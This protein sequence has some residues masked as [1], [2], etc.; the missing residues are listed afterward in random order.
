MSIAALIEK[1]NT[2]AQWLPVLE[3]AGVFFLIMLYIWRLRYVRH[4]S[5]LIILG[6]ILASHYLHKERAASL[7][8]SLRNFR[9]CAEEMAPA[10]LLLAIALLAMGLLM[11]TNRPISFDQGLLAFA[12]YCPWGFFQQYLLNSYF[13]NRF[14]AISPQRHVPVLSAA[15][16]SGA[17]LP[18]W[19]LMLVTFA[20]GYICAKIYL[21]HRNLWFLGL[22]HGLIG[23][24]LF[25][26]VP[27]SIS[28]HLNV[29]PSW[30]R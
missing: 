1:K 10:L 21:K 23:A 2:L 5:W 15:L 30:F 16:F 20:A 25:V 6:L 13:V 3:P 28:H 4:D 22:A 18:N 8:F 11:R 26:V 19:F 29:G 17:H 24:L 14:Q 12:A 27:D 7:G 9:A